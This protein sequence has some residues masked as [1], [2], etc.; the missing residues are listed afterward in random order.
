MSH[1]TYLETMSTKKITVNDK[2]LSKID[3]VLIMKLSLTDMVE[4]EEYNRGKLFDE[5]PEGWDKL[6]DAICEYTQRVQ[7]EI[8]EGIKDLLINGNAR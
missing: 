1:N 8:M 5:P 3:M 6:E 7:S 2:L 4:F